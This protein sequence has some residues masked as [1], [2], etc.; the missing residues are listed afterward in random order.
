M[1]TE[2]AGIDTGVDFEKLKLMQAVGLVMQGIGSAFPN[3]ADA[4]L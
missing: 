2:M 3:P 1:M 4:D